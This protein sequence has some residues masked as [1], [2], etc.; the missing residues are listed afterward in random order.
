MMARSLRALACLAALALALPFPSLAQSISG[1][2]EIPREQQAEPILEALEPAPLMERR[3]GTYG[4]VHRLPRDAEEIP[5]FGSNLFLGGFRGIRGSGLNPAYRIM[6]GDQI[7]LRAWGAVEMDRVLPVDAQG[8]IFIPQVGPVQVQGTSAAELNSRVTAAI[9]QVFTDY[10]SV[11][12]NLQGVQPVAVFVTGFVNS[13]GR[14]AGIPGDSVLYFLDQASGIDTASGSFRD[15]RVIRDGRVITE[16]DLYPFLLSGALPRPQFEEGDTILV[17][18]RGP[19]VTVAGDVSQPYRYELDAEFRSGRELLDWVQLMPGV[20]HALVRGVRETGPFSVYLPM[21]AFREDALRAG[22]EIVFS[23]DYRPDTIVVELEGSFEGPSRFALPHDARL[24]DLLDSIPV[25]PNLAEV[26]SVSIKRKSVAERQRESL[27][28]SL[29]RLETAYLGASSA[30][31]EEASIRATEAQ[32]IQDFVRRARQVEPTGRMVIAHQGAISNIRLQDGDIITIPSQSDSLLIS[33]EV[34]VPQAMV[35]V[36]GQSAED[37]I[38]RAGGFTE[39][40]DTRNILVVRQNGEV[41]AAR[42]I[43]LRPG[44]EI[45]VL[46]LVPTKNLQLASTVAQILYHIA[47]AAKVVIDL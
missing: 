28:D 1:M 17:G 47:V 26:R 4:P 46:P 35:H 36:A 23:A 6:P 44:D 5:P 14:Y 21:A 27:E 24:M 16:V 15:I 3:P 18:P 37:Y 45:L 32:L 40:A 39:R 9:R 43:E 41:V 31:A 8:N 25:N 34:L 29:R 7:T 22:D 38:R 20:S 12:T 2:G 42:D 30:T 19:M 13:P 33:G 10:V 11:Y